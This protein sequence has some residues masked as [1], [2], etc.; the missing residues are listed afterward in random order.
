MQ[1]HTVVKTNTGVRA[2]FV[3]NFD[4][5]EHIDP[6][7]DSYVDLQY[8][9]HQNPDFV[10]VSAWNRHP[11]KTIRAYFYTVNEGRDNGAPDGVKG[12]TIQTFLKPSQ[13]TVVHCAARQRKPRLYLF[14]AA[15]VEGD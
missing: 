3:R 5:L 15:F 8:E 7:P 9:T 4:V 12:R 11:E 14:N 10:S 13:T 2:R 6:G 1:E